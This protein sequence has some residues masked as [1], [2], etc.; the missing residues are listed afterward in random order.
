MEVLV[1]AAVLAR[2]RVVGL[3]LAPSLVT[4]LVLG[5][6]VTPRSGG[7]LRH[8]AENGAEQ[9]GHHGASPTGTTEQA[10]EL[11]EAGGV[12]GASPSGCGCAARCEVAD[13]A[14]LGTAPMP[15]NH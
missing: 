1:V 3:V 15:V 14:I 7:G 6:A 5:V 12:H 11:I 4:L 13:P 10:G 8:A 9:R 2:G